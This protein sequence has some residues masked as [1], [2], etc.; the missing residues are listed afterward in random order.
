MCDEEEYRGNSD[1]GSCNSCD[2][3]SYCPNKDGGPLDCPDGYYFESTECV[4][5]P[6]GSSC[7][8]G[9][10]SPCSSNEYSYAGDSECHSCPSGHVCDGT[11]KQMCKFGQ[12]I[13][14]NTC[15]DCESGYNCPKPDVGREECVCDSTFCVY[16]GPGAISCSVE[17]LRFVLCFKIFCAIH[18]IFKNMFFEILHINK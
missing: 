4:K 7:T 11:D 10:N 5:C 16:S 15:K 12:Y 13:D 9:S 14:S 17:G 18:E 1:T 2:A 6:A 8:S 3:N